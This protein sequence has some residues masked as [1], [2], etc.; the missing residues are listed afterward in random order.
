MKMKLLTLIIAFVAAAVISPIASVSAA[1]KPRTDVT[2]VIMDNG[3]PVKN[4]KVTVTCNNNTRRDKTNASGTY[5][6]TF[7]ASQCPDGATVNVTAQNGQKSGIGSATV[8]G[9]TTKLNVAVV[10]V[11]VPELGSVVGM[12]VA[13]LGAAGALFVIRRNQLSL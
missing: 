11:A 4:A 5:L 12:S 13:T 9:V 8:A 10:N 3:Q 7:K 1:T 2:G 6:V